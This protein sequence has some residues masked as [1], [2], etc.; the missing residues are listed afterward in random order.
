MYKQAIIL[1]LRVQTT[2]G[3]L[4]VEQLSDLSVNELDALAVALDTEYKASGKKSFLKKKTAKDKVLKL[5]LDIVVDILEDKV[6]AIETAS[7]AA[8]IKTHN[9]KIEGIIAMKQDE[10]L[11]NMSVKDLEKQLK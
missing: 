2:R 1:R 7:N 5:S 11:K 6:E 3:L 10:E 4:S 9:Q 8:G